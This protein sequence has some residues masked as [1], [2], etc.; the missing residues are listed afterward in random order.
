MVD[1]KEDTVW[2]VVEVWRGCADRAHVFE[3]KSD[4]QR[5]YSR[6][7]RRCNLDENDVEILE[8]RIV[9]HVPKRAAPRR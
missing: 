3:R 7:R 1:A 4:A 2:A 6:L 5:L 8:T 9:K